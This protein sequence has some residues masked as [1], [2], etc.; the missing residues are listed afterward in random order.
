MT[1]KMKLRKPRITKPLPIASPGFTLPE[2]AAVNSEGRNRRELGYDMQQGGRWFRPDG[3]PGAYRKGRDWF[4][5]PDAVWRQPARKGGPG[6]PKGSKGVKNKTGTSGIAYPRER[7]VKKI[8]R[9]I[10][11]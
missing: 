5:Y 10:K 6:R 1:L 11:K 4:F 7:V 9:G 2:W 8:S 3:S